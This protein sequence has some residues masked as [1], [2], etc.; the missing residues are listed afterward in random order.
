M[1]KICILVY[2]TFYKVLREN[3][4]VLKIMSCCMVI[5][6][7]KKIASGNFILQDT[8]SKFVI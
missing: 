8:N 2:L 3:K 5:V 7:S 6:I 4:D 1:K